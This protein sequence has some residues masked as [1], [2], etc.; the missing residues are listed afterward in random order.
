MKYIWSAKAKADVNAAMHQHLYPV[1]TAVCKQISLT[2]LRCAKQLDDTR[3]CGV[4]SGSH[5]H[6]L[7][8]QPHSLDADHLSDSRSQAAQAA[9]SCRGHLTTIVALARYIFTRMSGAA[10]AAWLREWLR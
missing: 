1:G 6:G 2:R 5:V 8:G 3:Q 4:G 9:L 7:G 10:C